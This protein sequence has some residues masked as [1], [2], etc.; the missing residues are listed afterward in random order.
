MQQPSPFGIGLVP[1]VGERADLGEEL[2]KRLGGRVGLAG[3]L[4]DLNRVAR[5]VEVPGKAAAW[6]FGWNSE[7]NRSQRWFPQGITTS[8]DAGG[9][10]H[11]NG[12]QIVCTSWYSQVVADLHKG[13]RLTFVDVTER[14]VPRYRHVLLVEPVL[15]A[16]GRVDVLPVK[17][18]AGGIVW[19]GPYVHVAG[20]ARGIYS[21]RL[22]DIVKVHAGG[23][24]NALAVHEDGRVDTFGYRYVL[25][26]RFVYEAM[27]DR[28]SEQLR[29]SFMSVDRS[30]VPARLIA[31][32]YAVGS[33][34]TRL[35]S[36]A[37]D[38][39][40]S[41]LRTS[42]DGHAHPLSL[43]EAGIHSMQGACVVDGTYYITTSAGRYG[44]GSLWVGA[45]GNFGRFAHVLPVGPEDLAYWPSTDQLWSLTEYPGR[46]FVFAMNRSE[47]G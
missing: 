23:D 22:D 46:R 42:E 10:D 29:Y 35:V 15:R 27:A 31:G 32:E 47:F 5:V 13:S 41:L 1:V 33:M 20:T 19:H 11:V 25:P 39:E 26:V 24:Q 34:T 12:R 7:D 45:P 3:V 44:R 30:L 2:T 6:G 17:V 40:T 36:Y 43:A 37:I 18:H 28:G 14:A 21:F 4:N 9:N 8:A 38:P 16:N